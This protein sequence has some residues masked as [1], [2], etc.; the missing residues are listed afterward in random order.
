M[1]YALPNASA[2]WLGWPWDQSL[3]QMR[4]RHSS[5][6]AYVRVLSTTRNIP[7][8]PLFLV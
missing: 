1:S 4:V 3:Q 7:P 2:A 6:R 5:G 8:F